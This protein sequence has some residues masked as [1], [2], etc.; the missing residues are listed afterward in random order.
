MMSETQLEITSHAT[1]E[2]ICDPFLGRKRKP[3]NKKK[4]GNH[5][6]D[7]ISRQDN[8]NTYRITQQLKEMNH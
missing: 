1:K 3:V 5:R 6:D 4:F 2:G 8:S 7:E